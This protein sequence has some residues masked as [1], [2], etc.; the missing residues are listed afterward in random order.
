MRKFLS[1]ILS[2]IIMLSSF[3]QGIVS[4]AL[5]NTSASD[6]Y[7]FAEDLSA[8]IRDY[9]EEDYS[10]E[11]DIDDVMASAERFFD[12]S[13]SYEDVLPLSHFETKRLI[14]KSN[15]KIDKFDAVE[16]VSGYND[17]YI[18][19][20]DSVLSTKIAYEKYLTLDYVEYVEVDTIYSV[21][22]DSLP[23]EIINENDISG[24]DEVTA[25][26]IEW[27]QDK[28]GFSDIKERLMER[29]EDDY[30]LVAVI[31]SGVDTD[32]EQLIDRLEESNVN[33]SSTGDRNS[34]EDDYGHGTHVAGIIANNTLD[35]VKIKPYKVLNDEG[36]GSLSV[37][38]I[39]VDMAV[40]DGADVINLSL[41]GEGES[42]V[43]TEAVDNAVAN[44]V[45]V[46][47]AAGNSG[48]DLDKKYYSPACIESAITVSATDSNDKLASFS[49]YDG[50]IDIAAPGENIRSCYLNNS[51]VTMSGTSMAA[52]QV[53]AGLAIVRTFIKDILASETEKRIED[54]A[55][56]MFENEGENHFGAGVLYLKYLL[57][58]KP[59]TANPVF[60]VDS[61]TFSSKFNVELTCSEPEAEIYYIT[62][63]L[64]EISIGGITDFDWI[65]AGKYTEPITISSDTKIYAMAYTRGKNPSEIVSA[66]YDRV[67]ND[68]EE[69]YEINTLGY[70]TDYYGD[71]IDLCIPSTIQG[72]IVRGIASAA[73]EKNSRIRTVKLPDSATKINSIAFAGCTAL[74]SVS[75][76]GITEIA[77]NA[78]ENS[79]IVYFDFP[80]LVTIGNKAFTGCYN[81]TTISMPKVETIG[82]NAFS[83]TPKL[84]ALNGESIIEVGNSAFEESG[85]ESVDFPKVTRLGR[86]AFAGCENLDYVSIPQ[87]TE[88]KIGTFNNCNSLKTVDMPLLKTIA[89]NSFRNTGLEK[90]FGRYVETI[91]NYAFAESTCLTEVI[92]PSTV[93]SGTN[94]FA[95]CTD[96][97]IV[98][99]PSM[100]ELNSNSFYNCIKLK[101]LYLPSVKTV[102]VS[103]FLLS[104]IEYLK[105]DCVEEIRSL[106]STL[107]G[108]LLPATA[109]SITA[110]TPNTDFKVYGY[111]KTYA[112]QYAVEEGK[113]FCEV[114]VVI[115]ESE[116]Q[117]NLQDSYIIV[118]AQ[119]FNCRYQWYK[120][121]KISNV[122]G[123]PISG[124]NHYYYKPIAEDG[125]V[126]YYCV[127]TSSD[128]TNSNTIKTKP[129]VN[130]PEFRPVDLTEYNQAL[131]EANSIDRESV[132]KELLKELDDLLKTDVSNLTYD[133][134]YV[135]D[136]LVDDIRFVLYE[137]Y[138]G[139]MLGD[140][141]HDHKITAYDARIVLSCVSGTLELS[142][143]K[144]KSADFN[145]DGEVSAYD[146][147]LILKKAVE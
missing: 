37:I 144:L 107:K 135:V 116:G 127:I 133:S 29:I 73:F 81:L 7:D 123:T 85:I 24:F 61:C 12:K 10:D 30:V 84:I 78:F 75:G 50:P 120:N 83:K 45:N 63:R 5:S 55:I 13:V 28:I 124:A 56:P 109:N 31:D 95:N 82:V 86:N 94:A 15:K 126:A 38:A 92:L 134:Q 147:R 19:Q 51:Y 137:I 89:S 27:L 40:A 54:Y 21:C 4:F 139:V 141:N 6:L 1:L 79:S 77:I 58:E 41:S 44:D 102:G 49:N 87:L 69:N 114:P 14:V 108:L 33:L 43:M 125:A 36:K 76:N 46:V 104:S 113:E 2:L 26:A 128:G 22:D 136:Y 143:H 39:A 117:F 20:Y 140:M 145:G 115:Y 122:G 80:N 25:E 131:E 9:S 53:A 18:L 8:L 72:K 62:G 132:D 138:N 112:Q 121:D 65:S 98:M 66:E 35:N 59:T 106:P 142:P 32:H 146:V 101:M 105:F 71:E 60:S 119:G 103:A 67:V 129:I 11:N 3:S 48:K 96:L 97:Q 74:V 90:Y 34:C 88:L 16:C 93:S 68:E 99:L 118:N 91:G 64:G 17:L 70:I 52:P 110:I 57:D 23:S 130:A 47:V 111:E 42:K 100:V